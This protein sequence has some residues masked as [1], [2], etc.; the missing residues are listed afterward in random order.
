MLDQ[1]HRVPQ[2]TLS[3]LGALRGELNSEDMQIECDDKDGKIDH[4]SRKF[5]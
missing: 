3:L 4:Q 5:S 1:Q 2:C